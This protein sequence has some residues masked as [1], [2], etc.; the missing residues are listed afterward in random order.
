MTPRWWE[1]WK[2]DSLEEQFEACNSIQARQWYHAR[3]AHDLGQANAPLLVALAERGILWSELWDLSRP[4]LFWPLSLREALGQKLSGLEATIEARTRWKQDATRDA[5]EASRTRRDLEALPR[6]AYVGQPERLTDH[7]AAL[8]AVVAPKCM[9]ERQRGRRWPIG[10]GGQR[11][12]AE[13]LRIVA[14]VLAN[15]YD[16]APTPQSIKARLQARARRPRQ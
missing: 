1:P 9:P 8:L 4:F 15:W 3:M 7:A 6:S 14:A 12:N 2:Y 5:E 11:Y 16:P 13:A 10:D